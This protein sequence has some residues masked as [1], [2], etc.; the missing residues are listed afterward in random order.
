MREV[1]IERINR[2]MHGRWTDRETKVIYYFQFCWKVSVRKKKKHDILLLLWDDA[3]DISR[4]LIFREIL[5]FVEQNSETELNNIL[6]VWQDEFLSNLPCFIFM[7]II[8]YDSHSYA[9][10]I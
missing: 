4:T 7:K 2:Q 6:P 8:L 1:G 10:P 9:S 5:D 3:R